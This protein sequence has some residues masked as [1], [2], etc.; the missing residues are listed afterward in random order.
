[1]AAADPATTASFSRVSFR[2]AVRPSPFRLPLS[3][4]HP[5]GRL[6]VSSTVVALHKRNPKRLKYAA[7][8]QFKVLSASSAS[9]SFF[10]Q[11]HATT[12]AFRGL[13]AF[14]ELTAMRD[15]K[16]EDTGMLR[17]KVEPSG[18]DFWKLDPV[19][20][21]INRGAVGVIPTDTVY[22]LP[23]HLAVFF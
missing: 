7:E 20:D 9:S 1:M 13:S 23:L 12:L 3:R 4:A 18:E 16:R 8:R 19:I 2:G 17:V 6:R 5:P 21:L 10:S 22:A 14:L 15:T 11:S